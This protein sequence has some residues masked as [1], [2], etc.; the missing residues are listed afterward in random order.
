[1]KIKFLVTLKIFKVRTWTT[2]LEYHR[3]KKI[4]FSASLK[5]FSTSQKGRMKSSDFR[6]TLKAHE[7]A[8]LDFGI[9]RLG[10]SNFW[11]FHSELVQKR[12]YFRKWAEEWRVAA[13]KRSDFLKTSDPD[14][15]LLW[16]LQYSRKCNKPLY[17][18]QATLL[19]WI[20]RPWFPSQDAFNFRWIWRPT[21]MAH[22]G[23]FFMICFISK[24][25][26]WIYLWHIKCLTL[27]G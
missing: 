27:T 10:L 26:E 21:T 19:F 14:I 23:D 18:Q 2:F 17:C 25:M 1:M 4:I 8:H 11:R 15:I 22:F 12:V 16:V 20:S 24:D 6:T 13:D 9:F 5:N 7:L 3:M